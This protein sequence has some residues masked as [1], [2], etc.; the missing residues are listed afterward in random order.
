[1]SGA[2]IGIFF[3]YQNFLSNLLKIFIMIITLMGYMGSGKSVIS[4]ELGSKLGFKNIDLDNEISSEIR[5]SIPEIFQ[6]K[7]ELFFRKKEKETLERVLNSQ[8]DVILSLGGGTP[9]YYNNIDVI[10][11]RSVSVY[12]VANVNT[13]VKNLLHE[14]EKRPLIAGIKEEELPN[15]IGQHLMERNQYYSKAKVVVMVNDWDLDRIVSDILTEIEKLNYE[16]KN[17]N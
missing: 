11:E 9:C 6:K 10:N 5:L 2:K 15:F 12:L 13:L 1:L 17:K 14:R 4:K 3:Y 16:I 8:E 7:G